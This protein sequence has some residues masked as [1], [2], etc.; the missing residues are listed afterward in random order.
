M[1]L[2]VPQ[3]FGTGGIT[4]APGVKGSALFARPLCLQGFFASHDC[5]IGNFPV[6]RDPIVARHLVAGTG[7][8][9]TDLAPEQMAAKSGSC[10]V[11]AAR[12]RSRR[13]AD[14]KGQRM[15]WA[16]HGPVTM[17][18]YRLHCSNTNNFSHTEIHFLSFVL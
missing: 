15:L 2:S 1:F 6:R 17:L 14:G 12:L 9:G 18:W 4:A 3:L 16:L 10:Q 5:N 13:A 8:A 7:A 11:S